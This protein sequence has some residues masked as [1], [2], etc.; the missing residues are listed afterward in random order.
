MYN[1]QQNVYAVGST[2]IAVG[3]SALIRIIPPA[4]AIATTIKIAS[5]S[6]TL[7]VTP[8]PALG[9]GAS[10]TGTAAGSMITG[11]YF[12]GALEVFNVGGPAKF[13]LS[14]SGATVT[15]ALIFGFTDGQQLI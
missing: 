9:L 13:Y 5:G 3:L 15:A 14:A 1:S 10:L 6:G 7:W 8:A 12:L 4:Y 2:Q 11:G